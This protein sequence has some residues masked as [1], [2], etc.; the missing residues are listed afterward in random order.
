MMNYQWST[1]MLENPELY[2]QLKMGAS[3]PPPLPL[4]NDVDGL[5][6]NNHTIYQRRTSDSNPADNLQPLQIATHQ[7]HQYVGISPPRSAPVNAVKSIS[8]N[9][10]QTKGVLTSKTPRCFVSNKPPATPA[11]PPPPLPLMN[12][13][14]TA[15]RIKITQFHKLTTIK[16]SK[17]ISTNNSNT[18]II[19]QTP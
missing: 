13:I 6:T 3:P 15:P 11:T 9:D 16:Q 7:Y 5:L 18:I 12:R 4:E 19:E 14:S 10:G 17:S 8:I 2:Q 1:Y